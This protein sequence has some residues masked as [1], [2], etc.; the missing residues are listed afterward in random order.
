MA[1]L[2]IFDITLTFAIVA[3]LILRYRELF[4]VNRKTK[5]VWFSMMFLVMDVFFFHGVACFVISNIVMFF[6]LF[7]LVILLAFWLPFLHVI[8]FLLLGLGC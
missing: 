8:P 1:F 6:K 7:L 2:N 3:G 4:L 5:E